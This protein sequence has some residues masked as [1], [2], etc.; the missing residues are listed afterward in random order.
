MI[1]REFVGN[2]LRTTLS[3][4]ISNSATSFSGVN[5][6][7]FP[8]GDKNPF[9][10]SIGRGT[11]TEEKILCS[12]RSTAN[13]FEVIERGYDG[14]TALEHT[15]GE[16]IDHVLDATVIQDMNTVTYNTSIIAWMGI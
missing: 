16:S 7:S 11:A 10:I 8:T 15:I 1:R 14:T 12:I 3:A 2:A 5:G 6:S 13:T 9:V 4:N